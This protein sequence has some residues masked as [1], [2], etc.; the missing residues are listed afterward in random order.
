MDDPHPHNSPHNSV[1]QLAIAPGTPRELVRFLPAILRA[2]VDPFPLFVAFLLFS[3]H[4]C[5]QAQI[6]CDTRW[7]SIRWQGKF[8][9]KA[10]A[11]GSDASGIIIQVNNFVQASFDRNYLLGTTLFT[12][13]FGTLNETSTTSCTP[14]QGQQIL[15]YSGS[16]R[17]TPGSTID[18]APNLISCTYA[19]TL[20]DSIMGDF[21]AQPCGSGTVDLGTF[22]YSLSLG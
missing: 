22:P 8:T 20:N 14:A 11:N 6:N 12:N 4:L 17:L 13:D 10:T 3:G 1:L 19:L 7:S 2:H 15:K 18:I 5:A 16:G 21:S 9:V